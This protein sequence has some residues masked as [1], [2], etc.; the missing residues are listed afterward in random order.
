MLVP[1]TL[2]RHRRLDGDGSIDQLTQYDAADSG[3]GGRE[4]LNALVGIGGND[5]WS[6]I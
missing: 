4:C 2:R 6:E 5:V 1:T 3:N